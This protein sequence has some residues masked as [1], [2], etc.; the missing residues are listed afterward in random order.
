MLAFAADGESRE[1]KW[2]QEMLQ[3]RVELPKSKQQMENL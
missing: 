2:M 1:M 3:L